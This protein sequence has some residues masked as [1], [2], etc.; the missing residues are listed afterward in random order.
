MRE[1]LTETAARLA[2]AIPFYGPGEPIPGDRD[3]SV[4]DD[5]TPFKAV[6]Y[7]LLRSWP[8]L[9]PQVAGNWWVPGKGI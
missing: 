1:E 4:K 3:L 7:L 5:K 6:L 8:Y 2:E 9:K